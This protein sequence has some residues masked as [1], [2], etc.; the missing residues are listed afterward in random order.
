MTSSGAAPPSVMPVQPAAGDAQH[1]RGHLDV[2]LSHAQSSSHWSLCQSG[3][4]GNVQADTCTHR[5]CLQPCLVLRWLLRRGTAP[6]CGHQMHVQPLCT[7]IL[8]QS[9]VCGLALRPP[10]TPRASFHSHT[11]FQASVKHCRRL[12]RARTPPCMS[13]TCGRQPL[14]GLGDGLSRSSLRL[15]PHC[16]LILHSHPPYR[17]PSQPPDTQ[18]RHLSDPSSHV[19]PGERGGGECCS[20]TFSGFCPT[21]S[22]SLAAIIDS[23]APTPC[24]CLIMQQH[25]SWTF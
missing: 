24:P 3:A 17:T 1:S 12:G 16:A 15:L 4:P 22:S 7:T 25:Q 20:A 13:A 8:R 11:A 10:S 9:S 5:E 21:A 6:G 14:T 18:L 2:D 19:V 23:H